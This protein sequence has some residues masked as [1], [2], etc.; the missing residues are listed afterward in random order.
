M[1]RTQAGS[2]GVRYWRTGDPQLEEVLDGDQGEGR[3]KSQS[4][5]QAKADGGA[6]GK[7]AAEGTLSIT[8]SRTGESY[9]VEITDGT[10]RTMDLRQIKVN[11]DDFGMMGYDPAFT[12]TA[13]CRSAVTYIDGEAG[14]LQHRGIPIE[15][16]CEHSHLPRGR[17]P[18][19]LRRAS[20]RAPSW[21]A[22]STTSP[23]TPSSTRTSRS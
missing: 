16:L 14:V 23:T 17:L 2:A 20:D 3:G 4:D 12:N 7:P 10:I 6:D 11:E 15:Q 19:D 22:G 21:S 5:G 18:A 8:D 1:S 13:S 9:E